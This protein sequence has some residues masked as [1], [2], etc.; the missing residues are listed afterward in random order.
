MKIAFMLPKHESLAIEYLSACLKTKGHQ[1]RLFYDPQLFGNALGKKDLLSRITNIENKVIDTLIRWNPKLICF[2]VVTDNYFWACKMAKRIKK[3]IKVPI[4][5]GGIHPTSVP[6]QVLSNDFVDYVCVGEGEESMV[7]LADALDKGSKCLR[8]PNIYCKK[9]GKIIRNPVRP[10]IKDLD[11]LPFPDKDIIYC[12]YPFLIKEYFISTS[13]GCLYSCSYCSNGVLK[14]IYGKDFSVRKRSVSNVIE[15]L[16]LAKQKYGIKSVIFYDDIFALDEKWLKEFSHKYSRA[17]DLPFFCSIHP[18]MVNKRKIKLLEQAGCSTINLGIQSISA[19]VRKQYNRPESNE[20]I[21][22]AIS[23][24]KRSGIFLR[25]E[26]IF[27]YPP[28][29]DEKLF[30]RT[31]RFFIR[32]RVD[33]IHL[34]WLSYLPRTQIV[35]KAL[36]DGYLSRADIQSI[37]N[38]MKPRPFHMHNP[39]TSKRLRKL[40]NLIILTTSLNKSF[41]ELILSRRMFYLVLSF[42]MYKLNRYLKMI[43]QGIKGKT[44][45]PKHFFSVWLLWKL[46]TKTG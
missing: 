11:S 42:D 29:A 17:I 44:A 4:V 6:T 25:A 45:L 40:S 24:I 2:S 16:K 3:K 21:S 37:E 33:S 36:K 20:I 28:R 43:S 1:T 14:K 15:E 38:P 18:N 22:N 12:K 35:D 13:R 46:L 19:D 30:L 32:H 23:I 5:F 10:L 27:G 8:I 39:K 34:Y 7:D 41:V 9:D 31:I 26:L